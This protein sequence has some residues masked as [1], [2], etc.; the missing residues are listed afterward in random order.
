MVLATATSTASGRTIVKRGAN[1]VYLAH[2]FTAHRAASR[3][4][5]IR[6][7]AAS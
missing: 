1:W 7:Q 3:S 6:E 4:R 5:S 2:R